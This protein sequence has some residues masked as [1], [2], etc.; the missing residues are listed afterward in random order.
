MTYYNDIEVKLWADLCLEIVYA[1]E[2]AV[3]GTVRA[4]VDCPRWSQ[5]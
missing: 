2:H 1:T 4:P 5:R 3:P